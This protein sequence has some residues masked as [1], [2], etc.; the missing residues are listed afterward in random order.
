MR[1]KAIVAT[2]LFL[3]FIG[4]SQIRF[5]DTVT[6]AGYFYAYVWEH[7]KTNNPYTRLSAR[8]FYFVP[9]SALQNRSLQDH[10]K[11]GYLRETDTVRFLDWPELTD[12]RP[13][14]VAGESL[15]SWTRQVKGVMPFQKGQASY[16]CGIQGHRVFVSFVNMRWLHLRMPGKL[17]CEVFNWPYVLDCG[18]KAKGRDYDIYLPLQLWTLE[19]G[20]ELKNGQAFHPASAL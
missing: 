15:Q 14:E 9:V 6:M 1:R 19:A 17:A 18:D 4:F 16:P 5:V 11:H 8:P 20:V 7:H 12:F 3:P 10:I 2:L 13:Y